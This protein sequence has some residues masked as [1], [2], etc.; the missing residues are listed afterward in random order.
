MHTDL[1]LGKAKTDKRELAYK[2]SLG[3][4]EIVAAISVSKRPRNVETALGEKARSCGHCSAQGGVKGGIEMSVA[5]T[6]A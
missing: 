5:I 2:L 4:V 1:G 6:L 3:D